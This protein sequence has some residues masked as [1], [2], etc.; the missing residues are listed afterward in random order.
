MMET[1]ATRGLVVNLGNPE[2]HTILEYAELIREL[3]ASDSQ[4]VFT[5]PAVADDPQRRR[6]DIERARSLLRWEPRV[7]LRDGLSRTIEY[8]R[9][10]LVDEAVGAPPAREKHEPVATSAGGAA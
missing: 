4:F 6:P 1:D 7:G 10:E 8:F 2:E 3:T 9:R 5:E